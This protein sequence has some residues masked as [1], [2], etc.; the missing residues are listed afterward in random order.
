MGEEFLEETKYGNK[1]NGVDEEPLEE[2]A[3]LE[4][5]REFNPK[6]VGYGFVVSM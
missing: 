2:H 6:K 4:L 1:L 3:V 5:M